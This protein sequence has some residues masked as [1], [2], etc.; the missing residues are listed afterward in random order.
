[1]LLKVLDHLARSLE[2]HGI[3][4][5][6]GTMLAANAPPTCKKQK[7]SV[8]SQR[9]VKQ[10]FCGALSKMNHCGP[11]LSKN[12][13]T[14]PFIGMIH[15]SWCQENDLEDLLCLHENPVW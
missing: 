13:K 2:T 12:P 4:A 15:K 6:E 3:P 14:I 8:K 1:M 11:L 10:T 5:E 9:N 7:V